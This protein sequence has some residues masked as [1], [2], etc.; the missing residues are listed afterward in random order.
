MI[1]CVYG[2]AFRVRERVKELKDAFRAKHD[3]T[4]LNFT[5]FPA[6]GQKPNPSEALQ[7]AL[8]SPFLGARRMVVVRDALAGSKKE[9]EK[10]WAG[11][12]R[13]PESTVLV[14]ADPADP[15]AVE[16]TALFK[17]L[18]G[19]GAKME[20]LP[21]P[22]GAE[23]AKWLVRRASVLSVG[24]SAD[25]AQDL[26]LRTGTDLWQA[27][28]EL[29]KLA[30]YAGART[31]TSAMVAD[32][33][34]PAFEGQMFALMD[35]VS[36]K[37]SREALRMLEEERQA[38]SADFYLLSMLQRQVRLLFSARL[39]LDDDPRA[40]GPQA[41]ETLGAAPFVA[42]KVLS[43]ARGFTTQ[44]LREAQALAY[45]FDVGA[46][47]GRVEAGLAVDLL[48]AKLLGA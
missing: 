45:A 2:D 34:R 17:A 13:V 6:D 4:G 36:Q 12:E 7:S 43:Q 15:A 22:S 42:G 20:P 27:D 11:A 32:M 33:V 26:A 14:F 19:F 8:A 41:A 1:L 9:A 31:I 46:K 29:Q 28:T 3:P 38:G 18:Q 23:L 24:I 5:Q 35:M 40:S 25:A 30:A 44:T 16:K 37:R 10:A 47:S 39:L 21:S 48:F